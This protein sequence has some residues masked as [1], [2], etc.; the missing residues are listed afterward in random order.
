MTESKQP[1]EARSV[2]ETDEQPADKVAATAVGEDGREVAVMVSEIDMESALEHVT[3]GQGTGDEIG[4][5][6]SAGGVAKLAL[7]IFDD[8]D[9][10]GIPIGARHGHMAVLTPGPLWWIPQLEGSPF[11]VLI[12]DEPGRLRP[13]DGEDAIP[14]DLA[15]VEGTNGLLA[16]FDGDEPLG[17]DALIFGIAYARGVMSAYEKNG[18]KPRKKHME[19]RKQSPSVNSIEVPT[20]A[21]TQRLFRVSKEKIEPQDYWGDDSASNDN[22]KHMGPPME[23]ST[24][25][26]SVSLRVGTEC[27]DIGL[28]FREYGLTFQDMYWLDH[29]ATLVYQGQNEIT[30]SQILKMGGYSNPYSASS[31]ETMRKALASCLKAAHTW[32]SLD[33]TN[34]NRDKRVGNYRV[35]GSV[36]MTHYANWSIDI[37][38]LDKDENGGNQ[39]SGEREDSLYDFTIKTV[40]TPEFVMPLMAYGRT[41]NQIT[42]FDADE[43]KFETIKRLTLEARQMWHYVMF[44]IRTY[45]P[46]NPRTSNVIRYETMWSALDFPVPEVSK[47]KHEQDGSVAIEKA[48]MNN[49]RKQRD[50]LINTLEKMLSEKSGG[51]CT[52]QQDGT[53]LYQYPRV[54]TS[55]EHHRS[56]SGKIDGI[57]FEPLPQR[58]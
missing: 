34:E 43:C 47:D 44:R 2:A 48:R 42:R 53:V 8:V 49:Q 6:E 51:E 45:K 20:D 4:I 10:D 15:P 32:V 41:R 29:V 50:R 18:K 57:V 38:K 14:Y 24:R 52:V 27:E 7:R 3:F 26:G 40:G 22:D 25:G 5:E 54:I 17:I 9:A 21:V 19:R 12:V 28:D 55:W 23:I 30:G 16:V 13:A 37:I 33:T 31:K 36:T 46:S 1:E 35:S 56:K 58:Y 39:E 11:G